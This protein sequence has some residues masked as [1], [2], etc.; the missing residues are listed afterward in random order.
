MYIIHEMQ[1]TGNQ[2]ALVPALTYTDRN[3][4]DS[5]Y[6]TALAAAAIS[7]VPIHTVLMV[8]EHGNTIKCDYYEHQ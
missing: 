2:T 6:H 8:D 4:A 3:Q 1:T 7:S 5:A